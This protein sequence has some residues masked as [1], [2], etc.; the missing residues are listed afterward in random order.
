MFSVI[1]D[2]NIIIYALEALS[3][4]TPDIQ[5]GIEKD[6]AEVFELGKQGRFKLTMISALKEQYETIDKH[7]RE[8]NKNYSPPEISAIFNWILSAKYGRLNVDLP[9]KS[10]PKDELFFHGHLL[11]VVNKFK[12]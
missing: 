8:K 9:I 11:Q 4:I 5:K 2:T 10:N 12:F 3:A 1:I 6:S 7:R